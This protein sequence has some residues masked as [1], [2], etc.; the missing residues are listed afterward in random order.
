M[1][2]VIDIGNSHIVFGVFHDN[3]LIQ[4]FRMET[5]HKASSDEYAGFILQMLSNKD[6]KQLVVASV[7]PG[8]NGTFERIA[9]DYFLGK[10]VWI[11]HEM[12]H[13]SLKVDQPIQVGIDRII[14]AY[15]AFQKHRQALLVVDMGTATKFDVVNS[16][17]EF[18]GGV[19]SPGLEMMRDAFFDRISHV[20]RVPLLLPRQVIGKNT[21]EALQSGLVLGYVVLVDALVQRIKQEL[22]TNVKVL[23]T[24]G[25]S[26]LIKPYSSVIEELDL[27]LILT[28]IHL[29]YREWE[30]RD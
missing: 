26:S 16:Q 28:G 13:M 3:Q 2:L 25:V 6:I 19:I 21:E 8:L 4:Q 1:L 20:A 29:I 7:V 15:A 5:R 30:K 14:N 12:I 22:G 23:A 11:K 18:L 27:D 17:G 9:N 10:C 24:G